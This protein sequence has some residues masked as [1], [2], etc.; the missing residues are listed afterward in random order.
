MV[1]QQYLDGRIKE[2]EEETQRDPYFALATLYKPLRN[3]LN[4]ASAAGQQALVSLLERVE[5][6]ATKA[7]KSIESS[8]S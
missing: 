6:L 8:L 2:F 1:D 4:V 5:S 3:R 7:Q